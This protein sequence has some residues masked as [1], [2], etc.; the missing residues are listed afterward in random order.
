MCT[1]QKGWL[2]PNLCKFCKGLIRGFP[3]SGLT[4]R[5]VSKFVRT[6]QISSRWLVLEFFPMDFWATSSK[7]KSLIHYIDKARIYNS[8]QPP[9]KNLCLFTTQV[10]AWNNCSFSFLFLPTQLNEC[11]ST[12]RR[13]NIQHG[14]GKIHFFW[15]RWYIF[16]WLFSFIVMLVFWV[17]SDLS[18]WNFKD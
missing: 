16:K 3:N 8:V 2:F 1:L 14:N 12:R 9:K 5:S 11:N 6:S 10:N 15:Y 17:V 7:S 13:T 4:L 18:V